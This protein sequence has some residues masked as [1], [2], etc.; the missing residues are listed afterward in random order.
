MPAAA[1]DLT[2]CRHISPMNSTCSSTTRCRNCSGA[3]CFARSMKVRRCAII[4]VSRV[5]HGGGRF[6]L[7]GERWAVRRRE[8]AA[9]HFVRSRKETVAVGLE[10]FVECTVGMK[11]IHDGDD[12][13]GQFGILEGQSLGMRIVAGQCDTEEVLAFLLVVIGLFGTYE[14]TIVLAGRERLQHVVIGAERMNI[15]C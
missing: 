3:V 13:G 6:P 4:S 8:R 7:F 5:R 15:D 2:S 10:D 12:G 1:T 11:L 9:G 14:R